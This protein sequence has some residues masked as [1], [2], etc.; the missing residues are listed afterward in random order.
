[1]ANSNDFESNLIIRGRDLTSEPLGKVIATVEKLSAVLNDNAEAATKG[2]GSMQG[3][4]VASR[5]ATQGFDALLKTQGRLEQFIATTQRLED[6]RAPAEAAK[7]AY[8]AFAQSLDGV[9]KR[10]DDQKATLAALRSAYTSTAREVRSAETALARQSAVLAK[11]GIEAKNVTETQKVLTSA[12]VA[13]SAA[14]KSGETAYINYNKNQAAA[15]AAAAETAKAEK[16]AADAVKRAAAEA[17]A[18][19]EREAQA[20][21][22]RLAESIAAFNT[23]RKL[24]ED[25]AELQR[26]AAAEHQAL[27]DQDAKLRVWEAAAQAKAVQDQKALQTFQGSAG[28]ALAGA[29]GLSPIGGASSGS[30]GLPSVAEGLAGILD[31]AQQLRSTLE[32]VTAEIAKLDAGLNADKPTREK[33]QSDLREARAAAAALEAQA[34]KVDGYRAQEVAT[35]A[36]HK[37]VLEQRAALVALDAQVRASAT[38]DKALAAE[39]TSAESTL[40]RLSAAYEDQNA[41]LTKLRTG[42]S[43]AKI[44]F[45]NLTGE[46]HK[47]A[48]AAVGV[49]GV[50]GQLEAR[51]ADQHLS[52]GGGDSGFLGFKPYE[53]QEITARIKDV[54]DQIGAGSSVL[55]TAEAQGARIVQLFSSHLTSIIPY[56][57]PVTAGIA[58]ITLAVIA[59]SHAEADINAD[60]RFQAKLDSTVDSGIATG[61]QLEALSRQIQHLGV[62]FTEAQEVVGQFVERG[63][64]PSR[65][66]EFAAVLQKV[67]DISGTSLTEETKKATEAFAGG[68]KQIIEYL[69]SQHKLTVGIE[70]EIR[71]A[72]QSHDVEKAR[73]I[74]FRALADAVGRAHDVTTPLTAATRSLRVAYDEFFEA[75]AKSPVILA[76]TQALRG[77]L[78]VTT[79]AIQLL[80]GD[81]RGAGSTLAGATAGNQVEGAYRLAEANAKIRDVKKQIADIEAKGLPYQTLQ[82]TTLKSTLEG[83]EGQAETYKTIAAGAHAVGAEQSANMIATTN[84]R[85]AQASSYAREQDLE[86]DRIK[87]RNATGA[88]ALRLRDKILAATKEQLIYEAH[89]L[90]TDEKVK[91]SIDARVAKEKELLDLQIQRRA[92]PEDDAIN[93]RLKIAE[94]NQAGLKGAQLAAAQKITEDLKVSVFESDLRRKGVTE[95]Q[96]LAKLV[97]DYR[98]SLI[99]EDARKVAAEHKA[100]GDKQ[101]AAEDGLAKE[102]LAIKEKL[103]NADK[104]NLAARLRGIDDEFAKYQLKIDEA[105]RRGAS[106]IPGVGSIADL[107]TQL[108]A[109]KQ[110]EVANATLDSFM[111]QLKAKEEE[112]KVALQE[113]QALSAKGGAEAGRAYDK[114][115]EVTSKLDPQI[116]KLA[117]DALQFAKNLG[118]ATPSAK[119]QE[120]IAQFEQAQVGTRRSGTDTANALLQPALDGEKERDE[121]VAA[122]KKLESDGLQSTETTQAKIKAAY[123]ATNVTIMDSVHATQQFIDAGLQSGTILPAQYELISAKLKDIGAQTVYVSDQEKALIKAIQSSIES[124]AVKAFDAAGEALGKFI[125]GHEKLKVS[126]GQIGASFAS[127]AAGVLKDIANIIIKQQ[128]M[129]ALQSVFPSLGLAPA[130]L[131]GSGGGAAG[132]AGGAASAGL[133]G[134]IGNWVSGIFGGGGSNTGGGANTNTAGSVGGG[135]TGTN[136]QGGNG[137]NWGNLAVG[138]GGDAGGSSL[139][140]APGGG[141]ATA[142]GPLGGIGGAALGLLKSVGTGLLGKA[143]SGAGGNAAAST[144][145]WDN[146]LVDGGGVAGPDAAAAGG[147]FFDAIGSGVSSAAGAI[148]DAASAA[149][150]GIASA[151]GGILDGIGELALLLHEGGVVG[152]GA[153]AMR[154]KVDPRWFVNAPR[155]HTGGM[156]GGGLGPNEQA[157]VLQ[158]GETVLTASQTAASNMAKNQSGGGGTPIRQ[159]LVMDP[160]QTS[161]ALSGSHGESTVLTHIKNNAS[162]VKTWLK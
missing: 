148:G 84:A 114:A 103:A 47:L 77:L 40:R 26:R 15:R 72:A 91:A 7:A 59:L 107:Q 158:K 138:G 28:A 8:E 79:Q 141:G 65:I 27:V 22:R 92:T 4:T 90:D 132:A 18:A 113:I 73:E 55:H 21:Q 52:S 94:A 80:G 12:I 111:A 112:R 129:N 58:G 145:G 124:E 41:K 128:L 125:A 96:G 98:Q 100:T 66:Q 61:K 45:T 104:T 50:I 75:L 67:A 83:L 133:L 56:L 126:I 154:R 16:E 46:S 62:S 17:E 131:G 127:M 118:G 108:A 97:S 86:T 89:G 37:A 146:L 87:I 99:G 153:D 24:Q 82:L 136:G 43:A 140:G 57:A 35:Q 157:A 6:A 81:N 70:E 159:V 161:Q 33:F 147:G 120:T 1:M 64:D 25:E 106:N 42:L 155:F 51:L 20:T 109:A 10:S 69:E 152:A 60:R 110:E 78:S 30:G 49:T 115:L 123:A 5:D 102:L 2:E 121:L 14:L 71:E 76:V 29:P 149:G 116:E 39:V 143:A 13:T 139:T 122:E 9:K 38:V 53:L 85:A 134:G 95:E 93:A 11:Q 156:V 36:A 137:D 34:G 74:G 19:S 32:G 150:S 142:G 119:I 101:R 160:A 105:K 130:A 162:Q 151:G 135:G 31:P 144:G 48:T 23:R 3:L 54:F 63:F 117:A 88:E 68:A 44:D